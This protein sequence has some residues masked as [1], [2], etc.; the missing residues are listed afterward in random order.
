ML[1]SQNFVFDDSEVLTEVTY[2]FGFSDRLDEGADLITNGAF[3]SDTWWTKNGAQAAIS[4]GVGTVTA[5]ASGTN[6]FESPT[7]SD[8]VAGRVYRLTV[9]LDAIATNDVTIALGGST[10]IHTLT[11]IGGTGSKTVYLR[12][13]ADAT[14]TLRFNQADGGSFTIDDVVLQRVASTSGGALSEEA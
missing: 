6:G 2:A 12:A 5:G 1:M 13:T 14:P 11:V 10:T 3:D 7:L 4:G 9:D 8:V